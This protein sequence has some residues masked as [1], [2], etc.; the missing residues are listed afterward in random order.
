MYPLAD[1]A[2]TGLAAVRL[3]PLRSLVSVSALVVVLLPY[4]VG[5]ALARGLEDE[6]EVSARFGADLYVTGTQMG[7]P[8]PLPLASRA[9]VPTLAR[10]RRL[11]GVTE[12][13]PRLVGQVVL[14]KERV[15]AV[16]VGMGPRHFPVEPDCIEGRLPRTGGPNELVVGTALARRLNLNLDTH[17]KIPPFYHNDAQGD[18]VSLVVGIFKPDAPLWQA[19]LILTTFETAAHILAQVDQASDLLVWCRSGAQEKLIPDIVRDLRFPEQ[20]DRG[21]IQA[22]VTSR[23]DLLVLLPRGTQHRAGVFALHFVLAFAVGILVLLVTSG[24]GL[25]ERRRE[26]GI[27]KATGWQTDEVLLRGGVESLCL[28]L[29]GA[30]LSLV[31]AWLWL[32]GLNGYGLAGY[33]IDGA[34]AAPDFRV[35]F[36]LTPIPLLLAFVLSLVIVLTGTLWSTWRAAT[37]APREAM[38]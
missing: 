15:P 4:L 36:R 10:L 29:A 27:L 23:E 33:F 21:A 12:V 38:R 8:V 35:P 1:V 31:L 11:E 32:R 5:A 9:E 20:G 6:A 25:A 19:H 14:G 26:I 7:R 2:Q 30:C 34:G 22:R 18:R 16:L 37:A 28:A 24:L 13:V 3:H 17:S